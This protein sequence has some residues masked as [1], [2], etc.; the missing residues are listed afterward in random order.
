VLDSK[1]KI[2]LEEKTATDFE[3]KF[4]GP[5]ETSLLVNSYYFPGW[6]AKIDGQPIE[7]SPAEP[8]GQIKLEV[9][10]GQHLIEVKFGE[11]PIRKLAN[12]ISLLG[13][14]SILILP[15]FTRVV[16]RKTP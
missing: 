14:V 4:S 5:Q 1:A 7:I 3:I 13:L 11:S 8:L 2:S 6:Q 15:L 9:P 16:G 10:A 12:T